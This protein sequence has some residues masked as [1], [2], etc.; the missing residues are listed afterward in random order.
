MSTVP[1]NNGTVTFNSLGNGTSTMD[2]D[3]SLTGLT[4]SSLLGSLTLTNSGGHILTIQSGDSIAFA[5]NTAVN[6]YLPIAGPGNLLLNGGTGTLTLN[7]GTGSNTYS[8]ATQ[9]YA[10]G[11]LTDGEANSSSA[12][13]VIYVGSALH[14][15]LDVN[16]NESIG[17]LGDVSGG[18]GY[19][20]IASGATLDLTGGYSGT[21][22]GIISGQGNLQKDFTGTL[23]LLNANT[24]TGTTV[25]NG[26]GGTAI[27]LGDGTTLG[28]LATSGVSG[29]GTLTFYEPSSITFSGNLSG[30]LQVIQKGSASTVTLSGTNTN[31]GGY[32]VQA[33]TLQAGST[34]AFGGATGLSAITLTGSGVLDLSTFSNT[35]G[36]ISSVSAL[37]GI[38]IGSG[39][40]LTVANPSAVTSFA[41]TI[42]GFGSLN[43]NSN[44]LNLTQPS[45]NS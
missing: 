6:L 22:S 31:S 5:T 27:Q 29:T 34:S 9:V 3:Y 20:V 4:F 44:Q 41:G 19:V 2:A 23:T 13:S 25:I 37:S 10:G 21:F 16:F 26:A 14:G 1:T 30:A 36:S 39:A 35:V 8:G 12:N 28:T 18:V 24:Y 17:S 38:S 42:S 43:L 7:P 40:T 33:G 15:W 45:G 11:T 32:T